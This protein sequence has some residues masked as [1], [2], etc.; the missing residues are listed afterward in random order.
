MTFRS[1][2]KLADIYNTLIAYK[3][4]PT[5]EL[6]KSL[7]YL[8]TGGRRAY[9]II[10]YTYIMLGRASRSLSTD[11]SVLVRTRVCRVIHWP[12]IRFLNWKHASCTLP[13]VLIKDVVVCRLYL[14]ECRTPAMNTFVWETKIWRLN[15]KTK[16][17]W[18]I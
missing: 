2:T 3:T 14:Q 7:L 6:T 1:A 4:K 12:R 15:M 13:V 8:Q 11:D 18:D 9:I 16:I 5:S 10:R 17:C